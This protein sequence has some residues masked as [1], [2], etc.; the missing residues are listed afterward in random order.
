[1][2]HRKTKQ[3]GRY[4]YNHVS[5]NNKYELNNTSKRQKLIL[6]PYIGDK[7]IHI[8]RLVQ[9]KREKMI[10]HANNNHKRVAMVI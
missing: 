6:M 9:S 2:R 3:N 5:D 8:Y 7:Q 4:I 10:Y 1:M